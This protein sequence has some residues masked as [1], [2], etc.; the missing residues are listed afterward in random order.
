MSNNKII[1]NGCIE[2]F[3][4]ENELTSNDSETFELFCLS[5]I[6]KSF[7]LAFEDIQ[8]SIVDGGNDGGIDSIIVAIDDFLPNSIEDIAELKF[9]RKT[10]VTIILSQCKK[11]NSFKET[12]VDKL[13]ATIPELFNLERSEDA[14]LVR[15]NPDLVD[16]ALIAREVWKKCS[17][18]GGQ[19]KIIFNYCSYA[20]GIAINST[21]LSKIEQLKSLSKTHFVGAGIDYVN[22]SCAE[23]LKLYQTQ[24]NQRLSIRYKD[25]PLSTS[26]LGFGIGYVG[27]VKLADY[28]YFLAD[29]DGTIRDDLFES[30]IRHFQGLVDVNKKIKETI[31]RPDNEDFWWLNNG[32]TIIASNPSLVGTTLS[33]D[34]VQIVNGLQTSYSIYLNHDSSADDTRSVL[35]KVIIN[36]DK[37]TIDH[38]IASTNSQNPVSPA[39]LRATD[40]VQRDIE[41]FFLNAGYYYDRRKNYYKNQG[42]PLSRIFSIQITAQAIESII[43]GN[44]YTARSKPT[45]LIKEDAAYGRIFNSAHNFQAY[46]NSCLIL[47]K[48]VEYWAEIEDKAK[49][50][51]LSNFKLHLARI[52]ASFILGKAEYSIHEIAAIDINQYEQAKFDSISQLMVESAD[53]YQ[54][55]NPNTNLINMAK[56]KGLTD[57]LV[58]KLINKLSL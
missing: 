30:N 42:K 31:E 45:S 11:E 53:T 46:L 34:N 40:K 25:N 33:V 4:L 22:Y 51:K 3:K 7:D 57:A 52:A 32:I 2:Q 17:I 1:V 49:K 13:I 58:V 50:S 20:E 16:R 14:L 44:S 12:A 54:V 21:F 55:D 47:K 48:T 35:V 41:L 56:T 15:F 8:L 28:K 18:G 39:L 10:I 29:E 9:S 5:Q 27:T 38:I 19:L 6:T 37:S 26:Y 23:L 24:K 43:Y 36:E